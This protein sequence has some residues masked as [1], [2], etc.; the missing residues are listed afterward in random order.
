MAKIILAEDDQTMVNLLTTLLQM[1][2]FEVIAVDADEDVPA[3]VERDRPDVLLLDVHLSNQNGLDVLEAIRSVDQSPQGA[4][5]HDLGI[6]R[7]GGI[8]AARRRRF[9]AQAFHARRFDENAAQECQG[10][11]MAP[12]CIREFRVSD[13]YS[14]AL[15]LW[16]DMEKGIHVGPSDAPGEI[17]KKLQRDPDLFL[18]AEDGSDLIG[19]VIGGYDGRRGFIYHLAVQPI[20]AAKG[21]APG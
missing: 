7:K 18:V 13:D 12:I 10:S 8:L 15:R 14:R 6:E 3:A 5:D 2:G 20:I 17:E 11:V 16:E 21:W 9:S 4:R 19:T 1:D